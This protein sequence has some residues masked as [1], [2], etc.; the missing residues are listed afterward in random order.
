M[1]TH[2]ALLAALSFLGTPPAHSV[3][4]T[5]VL[6][7]LKLI[8]NQATEIQKLTEL[9]DASDRNIALIQNLNQGIERTVA[10]IQSI[11]TVY[12]R[13]QGLDPTGVRSLSELNH[14][15][16]ETKALVRDSS[17]T[18]LLKSQ[19]IEASVGQASL[20]SETTYLMGQ[21][22][23]KVGGELAR[24]SRSASPGRAAQISAS[25][26]SSQMLAQG[27][28]LQAL[29]HLIQLQA[30]SLDLQKSMMTQSVRA[31][32]QDRSEAVRFIQQAKSGP[33]RRLP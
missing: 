15:L 16:A 7:V 28:E 9:V 8:S 33:G 4:V 27:V 32:S 13:V 26:A 3:G 18:L 23:A 10:Q 20:Q 19:L 5:E 29:A 1:R 14:R 11:E 22:M 17:Q 31:H 30:Q 12:S 2:I 25:A 24:E 21:E 6:D